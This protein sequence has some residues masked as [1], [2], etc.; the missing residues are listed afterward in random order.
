LNFFT[1]ILF[2]KKLNRYYTGSTSDLINRLN[3][4]NNGE[5][6]YTKTGIPWKLITSFEFE[7]RSE[8]MK[9]ENIIKKRGCKRF[10]EKIKRHQPG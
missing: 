3:E 1:Y 6:K 9:Y 4:H 2:S 7:T 8:A 5:S 10:L